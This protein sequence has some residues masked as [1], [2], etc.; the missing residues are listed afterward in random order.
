MVRAAQQGKRRQEKELSR[1]TCTAGNSWP[2]STKSPETSL[3]RGVATALLDS[4]LADSQQRAGAPPAADTPKTQTVDLRLADAAAELKQIKKEAIAAA[5]QAA[6]EQKTLLERLAALEKGAAATPPQ[7]VGVS[8][9]PAAAVLNCEAAQVYLLW[10]VRLKIQS[11]VTMSI[12]V[13]VLCFLGPAGGMLWIM[14]QIRAPGLRTMTST[15][16]FLFGILFL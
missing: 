12:L 6:L 5:E 10:Y 1:R 2:G 11:T 7:H 9:D 3:A 15:M 14:I 8:G 16:R 13:W 4:K